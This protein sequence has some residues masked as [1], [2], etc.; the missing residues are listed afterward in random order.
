MKKKINIEDRQSTEEIS[1]SSAA[2]QPA[3]RA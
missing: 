2:G 3:L 1:V